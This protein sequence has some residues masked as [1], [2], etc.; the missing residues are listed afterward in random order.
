MGEDIV[1]SFE[2][3]YDLLRKEKNQDEL[4][5]LETSYFEDVVDYLKEKQ[6]QLSSKTEVDDLFTMGER[7]KIE[8]EIKTIK[9]II[10]ELY[11]RR[12]RKILDMALN[13]SKSTVS[14]INKTTLLK[15]ERQLFDT[16]V[17]NINSARQSI[18]FPLLS[19]SAPRSVI[20]AQPVNAPSQEEPD[21]KSTEP[22][23][24]ETSPVAASS[25]KAT[26]EEDTPSENT[27]ATTT[28]LKTIKISYHIPQFLGENL[29]TY[30]PYAPDEVVELP[31]RIADI[32]IEKQRATPQENLLEHS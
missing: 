9:K 11:E 8:T 13:E 30:G 12:E 4:Q 1:I 25:V 23:N 17:N 2:T 28:H 22:E 6:A 10:S 16:L 31:E 18:L 7:E 21:T 19:A 26:Q 27:Q 24:T 29:E 14:L 20:P 3:L 32:I 5:Q 15:E